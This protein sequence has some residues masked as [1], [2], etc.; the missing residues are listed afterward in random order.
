MCSLLCCFSDV[1]SVIE[2]GIYC[3]RIIGPLVVGEVTKNY[4][5]MVAGIDN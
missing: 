3:A 5:F 2:S 1:F 4:G